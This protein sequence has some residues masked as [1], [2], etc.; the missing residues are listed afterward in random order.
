MSL[1]GRTQQPNARTDGAS[2]GG[3]CGTQASGEI[4]WRRMARSDEAI[5]TNVARAARPSIGLAPLRPR[6]LEAALSEE[7]R[8]EQTAA[9][10]QEEALLVA[11]PVQS[12]AGRA[13]WT[14]ELLSGELVRLTAPRVCRARRCVGAWPKMTSSH[15]ARTCGAFRRSTPTTSPVW[16]TCSIFIPKRP[17]RAPGGLLRREP[18]PAHRRGPPADPAQPGQIER[19]DCEYKRNGTANL[20]VF[21][22]GTAPGAR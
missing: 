12:P 14:L 8:P 19:Y 17:I 5:A 6:H 1:S 10:G 18:D 20:F 7:P 11:R 4:L 13:R 9:L 15:G 22:D 16:R 2:S 3:A 21:L